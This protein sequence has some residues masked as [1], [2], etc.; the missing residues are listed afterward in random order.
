MVGVLDFTDELSIDSLAELVVEAKA[1]L[2]K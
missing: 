1:L 2:Q